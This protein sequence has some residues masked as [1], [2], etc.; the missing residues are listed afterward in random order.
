MK[1]D[2]NLTIKWA[3][4]THTVNGWPI[5]SLDVDINEQFVITNSLFTGAD[6]SILKL[7]ALD[8]SFIKG[9]F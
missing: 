8:G 5:W 1:I 3:K 4:Q 9:T 6:S 2:L 7:S